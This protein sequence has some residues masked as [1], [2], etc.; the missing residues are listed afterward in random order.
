[1]TIAEFNAK[2]AKVRESREIGKSMLANAIARG[3]KRKAARVRV[4]IADANAKLARLA[5]GM[6]GRNPAI[7]T[8][9]DETP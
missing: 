4:S 1:M 3:D 8:R 2:I 7:Q 9:R 6:E 5:R